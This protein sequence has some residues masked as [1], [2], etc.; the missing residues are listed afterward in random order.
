MGPSKG[1]S[2][3]EGGNLSQ[4]LGAGSGEGSVP[5]IEGPGQGRQR[6]FLHICVDEKGQRWG[7][8]Q[9]HCP[10]PSQVEGPPGI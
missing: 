10:F 1:E 2:P 5:R 8:P 9:R 3:W 6:G 4:E 7:G